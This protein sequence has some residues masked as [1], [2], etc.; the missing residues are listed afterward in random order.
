MEKRPASRASH[1]RNP[2]QWSAAPNP[3]MENRWEQATVSWRWLD[4]GR[5]WSRDLGLGGA[6]RLRDRPGAALHTRFQWALRHQPQT[7]VC[8]L[9]LALSWSCTYQ[10]ERV[11]GSIT[12][13]CGGI[14]PSECSARRARVGENFRGKLHSVSE[15]GSPISLTAGA[16]HR[17]LS[18]LIWAN[19]G[20]AGPHSF[21]T[22]IGPS[23][24]PATGVRAEAR[25][26]GTDMGGDADD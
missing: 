10:A 24:L 5:G 11:D 7:D 18:E 9:D 15:T 2:R 19:M 20:I 22:L 12:P 25:T 3:P 6:S 4:P 17:D 13:S 14:H 1:G 16:E 21:R 8:R 26:E 23:I